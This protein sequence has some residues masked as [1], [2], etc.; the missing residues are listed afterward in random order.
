MS[1]MAAQL[2]AAVLHMLGAAAV[3]GYFTARAIGVLTPDAALAMPRRWLWVALGVL[4]LTGLWM[5]ER[6]HVTVG[7][8]ASG[9]LF[10][11]R[12]GQVLLVKLLVA[13]AMVAGMLVIRRDSALARWGLLLATALVVALSAVL[14]R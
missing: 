4:L 6:W 12:F 9:D 1:P 11:T 5:L 8:V 14:V 13:A 10:L 2:V 3:L 7:Q